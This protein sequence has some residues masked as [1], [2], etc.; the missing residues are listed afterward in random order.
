M[1]V[2]GDEN[3]RLAHADYWDERYAEIHGDQQVHEWFRSY[4]DLEEFFDRHLFQSYPSSTAPR[5]LHLG[6]GDSTVPQNLAARGYSDQLCVDFSAIVVATMAKRHA[7]LG[8]ADRIRWE[9]MDVRKMDGVPDA[10]VDVAFDK[11]TLDAMIHGS[12]WSPP[13]DTVRNTSAYLREVARVLKPS[14]A[15]LYVTYRQPHFVKPLLAGEGVNWD[16]NVE[17]LGASDGSFGYHGIV[18]RP[19]RG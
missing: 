16:I 18:C 15:F 9:Q 12:P 8:L 19:R 6:S 7:D 11:G 4:Q 14:G 17:L 1:P 5:I 10:S 2:E 3:E 13:E